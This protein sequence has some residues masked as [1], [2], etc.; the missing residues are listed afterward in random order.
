MRPSF[1]SMN[2]GPRQ[3]ILLTMCAFLS[4][5]ILSIRA[6]DASL[7]EFDSHGDIGSPKL[8]GSASYDPATQE[9]TLTGAGTNMW[10]TTD[11]FHFLWKKMKG[12]FILRARVEFIGKGAIAHRKIGWMVRPSLDTGSPYAD[13][14]EH[15]DG[16]TCLQFR[17]AVGKQHRKIHL[18]LSQQRERAAIRAAGKHLYFFGGALRGAVCQRGD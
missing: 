17:R 15:G 1:P 11:Q 13:A 7:G 12:D 6:Q 14:A 4:S 2:T 9:Y 3:K 16:E 10:F 18:D 5:G 8:A